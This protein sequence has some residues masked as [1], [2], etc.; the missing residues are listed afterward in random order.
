MSMR[1]RRLRTEFISSEKTHKPYIYQHREPL[2]A[3][4]WASTCH[5][6]F[7]SKQIVL[8]Q[9]LVWKDLVKKKLEQ[10]WIHF[11]RGCCLNRWENDDGKFYGE[12]H[13]EGAGVYETWFHD[14]WM[15]L[16]WP[17]QG[18]V[19][20][21]LV[22]FYAGCCQPGQRGTED[23]RSQRAG[24]LLFP[25]NISMRRC[26][27]LNNCQKLEFPH[28]Y[29]AGI[30]QYTAR[31]RLKACDDRVNLLGEAS[32]PATVSQCFCAI[33]SDIFFIFSYLPCFNAER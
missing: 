14:F 22:C 15:F 21:K 11:G 23:G 27:A 28:I 2:G 29:E 5:S 4:V 10:P 16:S 32:M 1:R 17:A 13:R 19:T 33:I 3:C 31:P 12:G 26:H 9:A 8:D 6:P 25:K 7:H 20:P 30:C 18:S 24:S